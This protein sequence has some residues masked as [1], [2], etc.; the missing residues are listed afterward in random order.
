MTTPSST[1]Q[2]VFSDPR[3]RTMSSYGPE[4]H[5]VAFMKT[6][7]SRGTAIPDSAA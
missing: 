6:T 1:S 2:S 5:E 4:M 3:G 7:G